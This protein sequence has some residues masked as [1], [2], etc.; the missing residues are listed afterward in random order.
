[1]YPPFPE[2]ANMKTYISVSEA[3]STIVE[4]A[5]AVEAERIPVQDSVGRTLRAAVVSADDIPPFDNSAMDGYAVMAADV[6]GR[7][8]IVESVAAGRVPRRTVSA[9]TCARIMTGAPIPRGA[10]AVVPVEWTT[11]VAAGVVDVERPVGQQAHIRRAGRDV[12]A[13]ERVLAAGTRI[14]PPMVGM[15]TAVGCTEVTV[16]RLPAVAVVST[17]DELVPAAAA[18][19]PGKIRDSNGPGLAAQVVAAGGA[20][21]G[22]YRAQD[23]RD[24]IRTVIREA[25]GADLLVFSG[26]VSVGGHDY[27]KDVLQEMGMRS[28]FWKVRQ[29]PGK[30]LAFGLLEGTPVLGLP[31][32]PVS[33][34]ICFDQY[35]RTAL[36]AMLGRDRIMRQRHAAV[37]VE[38]TPKKPGLHHFVRGVATVDKTAT[39]VVRDTGSQGSNIYSSMVQ[40]NCII[41]LPED[42]RDAPAGSSVELE[43]LRW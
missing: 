28:L 4:H 40:A 34:A 1:M 10:D 6:P 16:S 23:N 9:G 25:L 17:G 5:A 26:G 13:Q 24:S 36:A 12:R 30:P 14:T 15:M 3:R 32:N 43:W 41:H 7:L 38:A 39:L 20:V 19:Q 37:L 22:F 21:S 33:S 29:R 2:V 18:L 31:G 42:M 35:G 27:V 11:M 8:R